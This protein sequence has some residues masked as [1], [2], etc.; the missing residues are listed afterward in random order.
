MKHRLDVCAIVVAV[1][2]MLGMLTM[3]R[4]AVAQGRLRATPF[5]FI[6]TA[7][8]CGVAGSHIVTAGWL[9][10]MGLPDN[11]GQNTTLLDL[12]TNPNK[13]DPHR[14]LLLSKNGPTPDCSSAGATI[15]GFRR[16]ITLTELG[17]D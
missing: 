10:G 16:P 11:G 6:G 15:T 13:N 2:F 5:A 9:G 3:T 8:E 7:A 1:V 12:A 17:F 14:G 4:D